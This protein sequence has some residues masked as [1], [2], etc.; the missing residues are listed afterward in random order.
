MKLTLVTSAVLAFGMAPGACD[1]TGGGTG[2]TAG[3]GGTG[4]SGGNP[5]GHTYYVDPAKGSASGDGSAAA[6]WHTIQ[7]VVQ[8]GLLGS[9]VK[10]GDLVLLRSGYHGELVVSGGTYAAP[11]TIAADSGQTPKVRRVQA[12]GVTGLV[13]RGLS[14]SPSHAPAYAT[15]TMVNVQSS[16]SNVTLENCQL[17]SVADASAWTA[18]D[19]IDVA[20]SGIQ[21]SGKAV[22]IRNNTVKNVRF[23]ISV[24]GQNAL[25]DGNTVDSFSADG[26]RG[27]GDNGTFQYN[28]V[29][30]CYVDG[31]LDSN[32]DDGFQSWSNGP[33]GVGT[34]EVKGIVLRGNIFINFENPSQPFRATMQGIGCFDGFFT[35]WVVEN[36]VVITNHWHGIS[37]YGAKNSR[38][39]NNT[40]IDNDNTSPGPPWIMVTAHKDGRPSDNVVVRNNLATDYDVS[41]TNITQ[42]HNV[43]LTSST[44]AAYFVNPNAFNLH[45]KVGSPAIDAGSATLAPSL[46]RDRV[47]RPQGASFDLGAYEFR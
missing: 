43:T 21:V 37:L 9:K 33:S 5:S 31:D 23:G 42:D 46:D 25:I 4:G 26:M 20:S 18:N 6:P 14:I 44:L 19:W 8:A 38:V 39:V 41:G 1:G 47:A 3:T 13:L 30:N 40:V 12:S 15:L 16:S 34:G 22:T 17:F 28:T 35:D 2:G 36:N 27:L 24:D 45:L 11:I 10:A 32:H 7:E 29:K